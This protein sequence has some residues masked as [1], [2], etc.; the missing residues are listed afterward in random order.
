MRLKKLTPRL[1][2]IKTSRLTL[3]PFKTLIMSKALEHY[4]KKAHED[5]VLAGAIGIGGSGGT[6]IISS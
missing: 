3:S 5:H 2:N 1:T 6:F 4:L